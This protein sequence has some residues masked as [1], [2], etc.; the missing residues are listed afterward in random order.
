VLPPGEWTAPYPL[1]NR[2]PKGL[3]A[4]QGCNGMLHL[5]ESFV[6]AAVQGLNNLSY[7][8]APF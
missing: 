3:S 6:V 4:V 8:N 7:F 1:P 2:R 5:S